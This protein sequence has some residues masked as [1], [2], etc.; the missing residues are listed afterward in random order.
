MLCDRA[1]NLGLPIFLLGWLHC[2]SPKKAKTTRWKWAGN[3][4]GKRICNNSNWWI[5]WREE[6]G[7]GPGK[8]ELHWI[9]N[10]IHHVKRKSPSLITEQ[11]FILYFWPLILSLAFYSQWPN[12][13][14]KKSHER[15]SQSKKLLLLKVKLK[16][17]FKS[18][19][20]YSILVDC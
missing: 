1:E 4:P 10:T 16:M 17:M 14:E 7:E 2:C 9:I 8:A 18:T 3:T 19:E 12:T 11:S 5:N 15:P 20:R 13:D 6:N